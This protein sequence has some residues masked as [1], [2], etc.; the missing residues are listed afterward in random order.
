MAEL[1]VGMEGSCCVSAPDVLGAQTDT[2]C[3][4]SWNRE[5][6]GAQR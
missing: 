6:G 4:K 3:R 5:A 1:G 2:R